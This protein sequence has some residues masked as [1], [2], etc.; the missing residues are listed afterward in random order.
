M[1]F[2]NR[3]GVISLTLTAVIAISAYLFHSFDASI[4]VLAGGLIVIANFRLSTRNL[5]AVMNPDT[6][7]AFGKGVV[8]VSYLTRFM[9][10]GTVIYFAIASGIHPLFFVLGLSSVVGAI[11]FSYSSFRSAA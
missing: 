8:L 6:D 9:L 1:D 2:I 4:A 11:F 5:N 3:V 7:A 10:L